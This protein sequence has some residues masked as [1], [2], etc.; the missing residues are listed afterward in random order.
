MAEPTVAVRVLDELRRCQAALD[1]DEHAHRLKVGPR[2]TIKQVCRRLERAGRLRRYVGST[3][4]IVNDLRRDGDHLPSAA[5]ADARGHVVDPLG[6]GDP[7]AAGDSREQRYAER[8]MLE[9]LGERYGVVLNP[10][11]IVLEDGIRVEVDGADDK[12]TVLVEAWAHQ[13]PPK[14]AQKHKV[15]AD[16]LKLLHVGATVPVTPR[17][18]LCLCDPEAA[19]T[20]PA[21][22]PGQLTLCATS[23]SR[24]PWSNYLLTSRPQRR[25]GS[26]L[27]DPLPVGVSHVCSELGDCGAVSKARQRALGTTA[28]R[29]LLAT[30]SARAG[31]TRA[32]G[33]CQSCRVRRA[34]HDWPFPCLAPRVRDPGLGKDLWQVPPG[35]CRRQYVVTQPTRSQTMTS[36]GTTMYRCRCPARI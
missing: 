1:D 9:L 12:L 17:L 14:A 16:V 23:P 28:W 32:T 20:S 35:Y 8:V 6:D 29:G 10:R 18:V 25:P 5:D 31:S 24:S 22:D 3:G 21:P 13:G 19:A 11:R 30:G 33:T 27:A 2:Q 26:H 36:P 4:K 7:P 15:L 34:R